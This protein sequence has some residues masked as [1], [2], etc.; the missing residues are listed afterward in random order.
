LKARLLSELSGILN[1]ALR[2]WDRLQERGHFVQPETAMDEVDLL[3]NSSNPLCASST[4][5][6]FWPTGPKRE[7]RSLFRISALVFGPKGEQTT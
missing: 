5:N 2:G 7:G 4:M 1:W 6:A 3:A